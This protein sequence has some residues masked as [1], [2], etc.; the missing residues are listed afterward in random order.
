VI[1]DGAEEDAALVQRALAGDD[2]AFTLIMRRHK[3][4]LYR[5]ALRYTNNS[6]DAYDIVQQS[7]LAA[8]KA[9]ARFD[10]TKPLGAWLRTIALNKC[11]DQQR[12][13]TVRR[14]L[15]LSSVGSDGREIEAP[16]AEP[17]AER[18]VSDRSD[19]KAATAAIAALPDGLRAPLILVALEGLTMSEA[20]QVL[21]LSAKAVENRLYR[22][23][24]RLRS[25]LGSR[26]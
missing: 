9:L 21:G 8:W 12:R 24:T 14:W 15:T 25:Q 4:A 5:L 3:E 11:R 1:F 10:R 2:R 7:F 6:D 17:D 26:S 16:A 20:G 13:K 23:R 19:L 22:A 18:I